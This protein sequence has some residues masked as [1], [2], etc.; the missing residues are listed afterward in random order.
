MARRHGERAVS[1]RKVPLPTWPSSR[2]QTG[3]RHTVP[4]HQQFPLGPG[5]LSLPPVKLPPQLQLQAPDTDPSPGMTP[6][7]RSLSPSGSRP[8]AARLWA[9]PAS[10]PWR[11]AN[12]AWRRSR[13]A[14]S[15]ARRRP[16]P[17][18]TSP[19]WAGRGRHPWRRLA[20]GLRGRR[21]GRDP[22]RSRSPGGA[23]VAGAGP[24]AL[25]T[26]GAG[27]RRE[28]GQEAVTGREQRGSGRGNGAAPDPARP[29]RRGTARRCGESFP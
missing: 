5:P 29:A 8:A 28:A 20:G 11:R 26:Q 19:C 12:P 4:N 24:A 25:P 15:G 2:R 14:A 9:S 6:S 10:P 3:H 17:R 18:S 1:G 21:A 7:P 27:E 13:R 16:R 23:R 22:C